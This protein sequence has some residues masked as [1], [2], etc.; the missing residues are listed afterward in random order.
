MA[1]WGQVLLE[2]IWHFFK[3]QHN[4]NHMTTYSWVWCA[5]LVLLLGVHYTK[6]T[7]QV[8]QKDISINTYCSVLPIRCWALG[9]TCPPQCHTIRP[10]PSCWFCFGR[11]WKCQEVISSRKKQVTGS[12]RLLWAFCP[13]LLPVSFLASRGTNIWTSTPWASTTMDRAIPVT[14]AS[15]PWWAIY[16][17]KLC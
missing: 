6:R 7:A 5:L 3:V 4:S 12:K 10:A 1:P 16:Y 17:L 8:L 9:L 13:W 11:L 15:P 14:K 2:M